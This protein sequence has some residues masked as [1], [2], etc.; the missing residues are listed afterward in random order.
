[1][2]SFR[3]V[4]TFHRELLPIPHFAKPAWVKLDVKCRDK[5]DN[6]SALTLRNTTRVFD[7]Y[8][9]TFFINSFGFFNST[10]VSSLH[11]AS[12]AFSRLRDCVS[13]KKKQMNI[14][15]KPIEVR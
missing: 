10:K 5:H 13:T 4:V 11:A 15:E 12:Y 7:K 1:M 2:R 8:I 9:S 3:F 14:T 6:P